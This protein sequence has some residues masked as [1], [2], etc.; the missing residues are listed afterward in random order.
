MSM[1]RQ[2]T[3]IVEPSHGLCNRLRVIRSALNLAQRFHFKL[4]V[5]WRVNKELKCKYEDIFEEPDLFK[6]INI[7]DNFFGKYIVE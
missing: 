5:L 3:L 7:K 4:V 1:S 6:V 2:G